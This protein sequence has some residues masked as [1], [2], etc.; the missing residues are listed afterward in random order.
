[1]EEPSSAQPGSEPALSHPPTRGL[2]PLAVCA[3]GF[4]AIA[5]SLL[6][7]AVEPAIPGIWTGA[8]QLINLVRVGG[9]FSSQLFGAG[10]MIAAA[11]ASLRFAAS[12]DTT[13]RLAKNPPW[14]RA[15]SAGI[16][17]MLLLSVLITSGALAAGAQRLGSD[18]LT[19]RLPA[20]SELVLVIAV[21]LFA[22]AVALGRVH[23]RMLRGPAL[24]VLAAA[25]VAITRAALASVQTFGAPDTSPALMVSARAA[26]TVEW[27]IEAI[28]VVLSLS[29][30]GTALSPRRILPRWRRRLAG[31]L[32]ALFAVGVASAGSYLAIRG[33][34]PD[35]GPS[36][37]FASRALEHLLDPMAPF[38]PLS[39]RAYVELLRWSVALAAL[40]FVPRGL[41]R[42]T[43]VALALAGAAE[44]MTPL[45]ALAFALAVW[46]LGLAE[47]APQRSAD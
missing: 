36:A 14:L 28:L 9:A 43:T 41:V 25:A 31:G 39:L 44:A 4:V 37:V 5:A 6:V 10:G 35:A 16:G 22:V 38:V 17:L 40:V 24:A 18:R 29:W 26:A 7:R 30:I 23:E 13:P 8:D 3:L 45:G 42:S 15:F 33:L 11:I 46:S 27:L 12:E 2:W 32:A 20:E 21:S 34:R 1:M 19:L 47:L